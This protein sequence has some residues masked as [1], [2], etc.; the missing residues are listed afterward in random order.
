MT[1]EDVSCAVSCGWSAWS[2]WTRCDSSCGAGSQERF[3]CGAGGEGHAPRR[4]HRPPDGVTARHLPAGHPPTPRQPPAEPPAPGSPG[5]CDSATSPATPVR[6]HPAQRLCRCWLRDPGVAVAPLVPPVRPS[7]AEPGSGW[8]AWTPWSECS[9][10]CGSG[11]QRRHRTCAPPARGGPDC[12]GPHVQTREC[13]TQ[14]CRGECPAPGARRAVPGW[15]LPSPARC[16]RS[17]VPGGHAVPDGGAV[18]ARGGPLPAALPG[19]GRGGGMCRALPGRLRLPPRAAAA[20]PE[21]CAARP[22]SLPPPRPPLPARGHCRPR[23]L[24]QLVRMRPPRPRPGVSAGAPHPMPP[25]ADPPLPQ[26]LHGRGDGV[27]H[28]ALPRYRRDWVGVL[29]CAR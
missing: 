12:A 6:A 10:P 2:P 27:R 17:A 1:C 24:Q 4:W 9:A 19:P 23:R 28:R 26:H 20:Q 8:S 15:P 18:P 21:L 25:R 16:P 3:R 22:L 11:E 7:P 13:S 5:R 29:G 14:P